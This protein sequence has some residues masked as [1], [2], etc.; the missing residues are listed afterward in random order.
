MGLKFLIKICF[1]K[2]IATSIK[3]TIKTT[4]KFF[5]ILELC[6]EKKKKYSGIDNKKGIELYIQL[7]ERR[8]KL[9]VVVTTVDAQK[10]K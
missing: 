9:D 2:T 8:K 5:K 4:L 10:I 6:I 3:L 7:L 1:Q